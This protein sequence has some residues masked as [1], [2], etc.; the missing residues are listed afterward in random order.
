MEKHS[1]IEIQ[2]EKA[3]EIVKKMNAQLASINAVLK[4]ANTILGNIDK[5]DKDYKKLNDALL[6]IN[7]KTK[8]AILLFEA[9]KKSIEKKLSEANRFYTQK[10]LPL[11]NKINDP[12]EGLSAILKETQKD[13]KAYKIAK[14]DCV[15][16]F[17]EIVDITKNSGIKSK[18]LAKIESAVLKFYKSAEANTAKINSLLVKADETCSKINQIYRDF[19]E[20]KKTSKDLVD[21]ISTLEKDSNT[22]KTDIEDHHK[23][24]KEKLE[25]IQKIYEIAHETGLSGEFEKRRN[26]LN[27]ETKKWEKYI[28]WTSIVLLI[29]V[30]LLFVW[31]FK[32]NNNR[33]DKVFDINFYVRFLIFSPIVYYLY[34]VSTQYN[35][36]KKLHDKYAFKTTLSMTI[37]SH[38]ELLTQNGYFDDAG[39]CDKI[40]NFILDG[41]R[42]I[43]NEPYVSESYKMKIKLANFEIGLQKKLIEKL[44]EMTNCESGN[45]AIQAVIEN[46]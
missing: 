11:Q 18:E 12:S 34:F 10:Y 8:E 5:R 26:S 41:F 17:K 36:A 27:V 28:I 6:S 3:E 22:L 21:N 38:I 14:A 9:D 39:Q 43:Y 23:T 7:A 1:T 13:Y 25:D 31:Q 20:L 16:K 42:K 19:L 35:K 45:N 40:L 24:S 44:S 15:A 46:K 32:A 37:K 2:K 4:N 29:G 30:A 33:F